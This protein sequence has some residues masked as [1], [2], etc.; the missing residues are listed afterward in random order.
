[1]PQSTTREQA[2]P[3]TGDLGRLVA[4]A[5]AAAGARRLDEIVAAVAAETAVVLD[6]ERVAIVRWDGGPGP[7]AAA[8]APPEADAPGLDVGPELAAALADG[9]VGDGAPPPVAAELHAALGGPGGVAPVPHAE[10]PWGLVAAHVARALDEAD[11]RLLAGVG[12]LLAGAIDRGEM[13]DR[14]ERFAF[15][16]P[17]TGLA[18]RRALDDRLAVAV[19]GAAPGSPVTLMMCDVDGFKELNDAA[20][21]DAGDRVLKGLAR[22]LAEATERHP[23]A[24]VARVGGDEFCIVLEREDLQTAELVARTTAAAVAADPAAD[25]TLAW[26]AATTDEPIAPVELYRR[27]DAAQYTAKRLG[28]GRICL[29]RGEAVAGAGTLPAR[30]RR[31]EPWTPGAAIVVEAIEIIDKLPAGTDTVDRLEATTAA[32]AHRLDAAGW[33]ISR[34][35][36]G[37]TQLRTVRGYDSRLDANSG[38]RVVDVA[39]DDPYPVEAYPSTARAI[40]ESAGFHTTVGDPEGDEAEQRLLERLGYR[41]VIGAAAS[42]GTGSFLVE[43]F[44]D[45]NTPSLT[46]ALT[47]LRLIVTQTVASGGHPLPPAD[48]LMAAQERFETAFEAAPIGMALLTPA[49]R[50]LQ[51]NDAAC[52]MLGRSR[53]EMLS[54]DSQSLTHPDDLKPGMRLVEATLAGER[55]GYEIEKRFLRGDGTPVWTAVHATLV[56]GAHGHPSYFISQIEDISQRKA[57][58]ATLARRADD[59]RLLEAEAP[60]QLPA[61]DDDERVQTDELVARVLGLARRHLRVPAAYLTQAEASGIRILSVAGDGEPFGAVAGTLV[62]PDSAICARMLAGR[63]GQVIPDTAAIPELAEIPGLVETVGAYLGVPVTLADGETYG[64]ICCFDA[65]PRDDVGEP[66]EL[67]LADLAEVVAAQLDHDRRRV[68]EGRARSGLTGI[69]ALVTALEA[70]DRYTGSHSR[71][72]VGLARRVAARLGIGRSEAEAAAQV[73]L[74]HDMGKVAIPDAVLQKPGA[75]TEA[76]WDLMRQHPGVGSR[77]VGSI[78]ELAHLAGAV[79][80]EHERWDGAGYPDGLAGEDI[81]IAAR[82]TLACDAYDAMTSDRP[83]RAARS[84]AEA[85]EELRRCAGTQF[86]PDVVAALEAVL[87]ADDAG[88]D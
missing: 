67:L 58:E 88:A 71:T 66:E 10:R 6:A 37:D 82:I 52:R 33:S 51:V 9:P 24:L 46:P 7:C 64:T 43:V 29:D 56:R 3:G 19:A 14:L 57:A 13:F 41:G 70:R 69:Y 2:G 77:I 15:E 39:V 35:D 28:A 8:G 75:L 84:P 49:G 54:L 55:D 83:Y 79:R 38:A 26:G 11:L 27:A 63:V 81:P 47:A 48:E 34:M 68:L 31:S 4:V 80:A 50:I 22:V 62:P 25:I 78:P 73:A 40:A 30:R 5:T 1:M 16:D 60:P 87:A 21:H 61:P 76:E 74:L 44:A 17:L 23:E 85:R 86:D 45:E 72:V 36:A 18:N 53:A 65:V 32:F 20:G 12:A 42:D 59:L